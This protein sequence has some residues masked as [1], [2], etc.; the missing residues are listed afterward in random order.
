MNLEDLIK[1]LESETPTKRIKIGFHNPHSYRGSYSELAFERKDNI[2]IGEMLQCAKNALGKTFDGYK[3]GE[4][5]MSGLAEVYLAEYGHTGEE[6][7][8]ILLELMIN[9]ECAE[10]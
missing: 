1:K 10:P 6:I 9:N 4:Y 7:G 8:D 2:T 5:T 3:G